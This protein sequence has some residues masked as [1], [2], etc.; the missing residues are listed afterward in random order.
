MKGGKFGHAYLKRLFLAFYIPFAVNIPLSA[1][2]WYKGVWP[3]TEEMGGLPRNA[4]LIVILGISWVIWMA[5][6]ILP[7][8]PVLC[9]SLR[10]LRPVCDLFKI[11]PWA[12]GQT[13]GQP[14]PV[15]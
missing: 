6:Q 2:A 13:G 8:K 3:G 12:Y 4:A 9:C 1:Y 11:V 10:F 15:D 14:G 5:Y 7:R